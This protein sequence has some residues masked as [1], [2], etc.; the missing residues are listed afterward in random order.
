MKRIRKYSRLGL[1][2]CVLVTWSSH[3]NYVFIP[4]LICLILLNLL[5]GV[6][7]NFDAINT[8]DYILRVS[9]LRATYSILYYTLIG[10][11]TSND[12]DLYGS[13]FFFPQKLWYR[14]KQVPNVLFKKQQR[15][16]STYTG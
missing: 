11:I 5:T 4:H 16:R 7:C 1:E 6:L 3:Y 10:E 2:Q 9:T 13:L 8:D 15:I 12:L 14:V